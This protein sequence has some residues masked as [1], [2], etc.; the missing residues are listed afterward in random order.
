MNDHSLK[1]FLAME[2]LAKAKQLEKEGHNICHLEVGEPAHSPA[3]NVIKAMH[4]A[5]PNPQ[6][7]THAKGVEELR[8]SLCDFYREQH[9]VEINKNN[10]I[11]TMG[12]SA[13]FTLAFLSGFKK[14]ARIA[15][16][17]PG[18]PA[19]LNILNGLGFEV[20]EIGLNA[21][22]KWRL[23][24]NDIEKAYKKRPFDGLLFA[25]PANPTG[26]SISAHEFKKIVATCKRLGVRFIS[27]EI[28][29]G[30]DFT[31]NSLS[32]LEFDND[33]IVVNSFSK[34]FCM[35]GYRIGWLV[36]PDNLVRKTEMLAQNMFI[37]APSLSQVGAIAALKEREYYQ[38]KKQSY[39]QNRDILTKGLVE[40]GFKNV[41]SADGAFY[42][43]VDVS[44]LTND[45]FEFCQKLLQ[46]AKVGATPGADFDRIDGNKYVRFS[47]AGKRSVIKEALKRMAE[48]LIRPKSIL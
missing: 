47:F 24:A 21:K 5:L 35:T 1:P 9:S 42:T 40:L 27:D 6:T 48:F 22:N 17:R 7:Y 44:N 34:Y 30:L 16:T 19:Y 33:L 36:L 37:S 18:Y 39:L 4:E 14:G 46:E 15:L 8:A 23:S 11:I 45:S 38:E 32:A 41:L 31:Q 26:A 25:S 28:Y 10:I 29:N 12:S 3:P 2:V 43:Y 20:E 13:G